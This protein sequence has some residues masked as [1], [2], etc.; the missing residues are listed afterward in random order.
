[1]RLDTTLIAVEEGRRLATADVTSLPSFFTAAD[2]I[3]EVDVE[4]AVREFV[5]VDEEE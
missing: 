5:A 3:R 1:M 4:G 2:S